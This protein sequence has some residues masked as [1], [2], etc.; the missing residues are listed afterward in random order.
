[1]KNKLNVAK[2]L[3]SNEKMQQKLQ[4][5]DIEQQINQFYINRVSNKDNGVL[6]EELFI[7]VLNNI[8]CNYKNSNNDIVN[9]FCE[10]GQKIISILERKK[11]SK[12]SDDCLGYALNPTSDYK[13][14]VILK[15]KNRSVSRLSL[16]TSMSSKYNKQTY[17]RVKQH[18]AKLKTW[19]ADFSIDNKINYLNLIF[20]EQ[21]DEA[22]HWIVFF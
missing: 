7:N 12:R 10:I 13:T 9:E 8:H 11:K 4:I 5:N 21:H 17:C 16:K 3:R 22:I 18:K 20:N 14:D 1:M 15:H 19:F 6:F 2:L